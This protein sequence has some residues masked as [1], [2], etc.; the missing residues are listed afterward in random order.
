MH[1][2]KATSESQEEVFPIPHYSDCTHLSSRQKQYCLTFN[3][4]KLMHKDLLLLHCN[5]PLQA[6]ITQL[7]CKHKGWWMLYIMPPM[8][9]KQ[10]ASWAYSA[11]SI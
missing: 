9:F 10:V 3:T 4:I 1:T 6:F 7:A 8:S 11:P 2:N 5:K